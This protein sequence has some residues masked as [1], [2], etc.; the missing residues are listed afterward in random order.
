MGKIEKRFTEG[1]KRQNVKEQSQTAE[2]LNI[3]INT[4]MKNG[5]NDEINSANTCMSRREIL[6]YSGMAGS[7]FFL[8]GFLGGSLANATQKIYQKPECKTLTG[9][10]LRSTSVLDNATISA[11]S[12][13]SHISAAD[14]FG[15]EFNGDEIDKTHEIFWNIEEYIKSKGGLPEPQE[16]APVVIVG[17][18]LSGLLSAYYMQDQS[19]IVLESAKQFGGNCKGESTQSNQETI[20]S[21]GAA[22]ITKP[23]EGSDVEKLLKDLNL[24]DQFRE[25]KS[26]EAQVLLKGKMLKSFWEGESDVAAKQ[27]FLK[28]HD[29]LK[30]ILENNYPEIPESEDMANQKMMNELDQITFADWL[31]FKWGEVHPHIKEYF[32]LYCWSSFGGSIDEISAAQALNFLAPETDSVYAFPGGNAAI[33]QALYER[34]MQKLKANSLRTQA[35]VID[36]IERDQDI[37]VTYVDSEGELH[38]IR[39]SKCI[40]ASSKM[41]AK[42]IIPGMPAAQKKACEEITYRAYIVANVLVEKPFQSPC[43]DLYCLKGEMPQSP[44]ALNPPK[45]GFTDICFGSWAQADQAEYSILTIYKPLP[46]QGA[47]QF[48]FSEFSHEKHKKIITDAL[49][50]YLPLMNTTAD[51]IRGMRLTRWGHAMPLAYKGLISSGVLAQ[52]RAPINNKIFFANQDNWANPSFETAIM[53]AIACAQ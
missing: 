15:K 39:T 49:V 14:Y 43:Y 52:A 45:R 2:Q 31:K 41:I 6:K 24:F 11:G 30:N 50:D 27:E 51:K 36:I 42:T 25:E 20:F 21:I 7:A 18:G 38:S 5:V 53:S 28:I 46:Y 34:L 22:Y 3:G 33:A 29:E 44:T 26:D 4:G 35:M 17:G 10:T 19:P 1:Q 23:D 37:I 13:I 32:Q 9:G 16:F 40:V 12:P 48:L 8:N 47:L